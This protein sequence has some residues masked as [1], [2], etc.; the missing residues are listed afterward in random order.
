M[1]WALVMDGI[2][3]TRGCFGLFSPGLV[4]Q[5]AAL[6]IILPDCGCCGSDQHSWRR[7]RAEN[8]KSDQLYVACTAAVGATSTAMENEG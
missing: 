1:L 3:L 5:N 6:S 2:D 7:C 8:D 4:E